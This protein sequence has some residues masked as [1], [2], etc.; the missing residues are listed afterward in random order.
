[1]KETIERDLQSCGL[2][3]S[4]KDEVEFVRHYK[5]EVFGGR[6]CGQKLVFYYLFDR[7][8]LVDDREYTRV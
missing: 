1:M 6:E 8:Q 2:P 5:G 3:K 7:A 4:Y